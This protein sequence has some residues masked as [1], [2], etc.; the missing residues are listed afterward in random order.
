MYLS[1]FRL[2][3]VNQFYCLLFLPNGSYDHL[4][5]RHLQSTTLRSRYDSYRLLIFVAAELSR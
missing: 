1:V 3:L 2:R 4:C 5:S